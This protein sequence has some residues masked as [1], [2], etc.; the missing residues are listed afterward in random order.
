VESV[1]SPSG[2]LTGRPKDYYDTLQRTATCRR[3]G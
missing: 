1:A 3:C 2:L